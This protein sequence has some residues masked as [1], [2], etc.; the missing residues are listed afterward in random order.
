MRNTGKVVAI[1]LSLAAFVIAG[2]LIA[3]GTAYGFTSYLNDFLAAYPAADNTQLNTCGLCHINPAGGGALNPYG[4]D[5]ADPAIGNHTF[6]ATLEGT[7]SDLDTFTN[8]VEIN[9]LTFPG[10]DTSFPAAVDNTAPTVD[11]I[12]PADNAVNVPVNTL[13]AA[14]F[15]EAI[16]TATV[17]DNSFFVNDG[18]D[19]VAGTIAFSTD[20][21]T[22]TFTSAAF[23]DNGVTYTATLTSAVMDLAGNALDN[24]AWTFT[25]AADN[26]ADTTA[27]SVV[28]TSPDNNAT[29]VA[30]NTSIMA[31]FSEPIDPASV[32]GAS[33]TLANGGAVAGTISVSVTADNTVTFTPSADLAA[34]TVYTVTLSTG[35]TDLAGVPLDNNY[36]WTFTTGVG[37]DVTPPTVVSTVPIDGATGVAVNT[38]I[39]A[40]FSE[41]I[42]PASLDNTSFVTDGTD[43]VDGTLSVVG[44]TAT[45][46]PTA[47]LKTSTLYTVTL[48]TNITDLAGNHLAA[49]YTW[50]FTTRAAS[51]S[52]DGGGSCSVI[53]SRGSGGGGAF[54]FL[55]LLAILVTLRRMGARAR[56]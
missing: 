31:M 26:T 30:T 46:T 19:N 38:T 2:M 11:A 35:V 20:N 50:S 12:F 45:F 55:T 7:D 39:S 53:G 13:V 47:N 56:L 24:G 18:V 41:A 25:T 6:N 3:G 48:S 8:I 33:F 52:S 49:P 17:T 32:T 37:N 51:S 9:A 27:P 43:N 23:L 36:V 54:L 15:S 1:S 22:A 34:L 14:R 44:N 21:T 42:D 29:N 5:Y 16:N 10:D 40:T 4:T 28:S